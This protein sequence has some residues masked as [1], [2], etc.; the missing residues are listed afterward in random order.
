MIRLLEPLGH[1]AS[2][3]AVQLH[4]LGQ[5]WTIC[6]YSDLSDA[7]PFTCISYA[8]GN[9]KI[10][11]P[12]GVEQVMSSRT[13]GAIEGAIN[14]AHSPENWANCI[15]LSQIGSQQKEAERRAAALEASQAFWIDALC[16][17]INDPDRTVCLQRMGDIFGSAVQ[18]IV[19]LGDQCSDAVQSV[20]GNAKMSLRDL[21]ALEQEDWIGRA[22]T[23]QEAV[24]SKSLYFVAEGTRSEMVSGHN[25]LNAVMIAIDEYKSHNGID[26]MAWE[27]GSGKLRS[28]ERLL[29]DY[30]ISD[31]ETRSAYQVMS[32]MEQRFSERPEDHFYAMVGAISATAR[33]DGDEDLSPSE[34][35]MRACERKADF[36]FIYSTAPRSQTV[37]RQWKPVE[38]RFS[39]VL[40]NLITFGNQERG[41]AH[42][43]HVSL[44]NMYRL[45]RGSVGADGLKSARWFGRAKDGCKS[46]EEIASKILARLR[47]LGFTGSGGYMEFETGFF[48]PQ[49]VSEPSDDVIA[50]VSSDIHWVTGGP[51]LLLRQNSNGIYDFCDG[52]AFVGKS[53]KSGA[54]FKV[55]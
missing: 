26:D 20:S 9:E 54:I 32:V 38:G 17:P 7:P 31:Y 22:W 42:P 55:G 4:I 11:S 53:P 28:L 39:P 41:T 16:V 51:G 50:V 29:A 52:G 6:E 37:G 49:S 25:F 27:K 46:P 30:L 18:V 3:D 40:P 21:L 5:K 14:A 48:F 12:F 2:Y 36:S 24:N 44:E 23:Y 47:T 19:V 15:R 35:F 8:W 1:D 45:Q 13:I 10:A 34:Y 33:I 43:T